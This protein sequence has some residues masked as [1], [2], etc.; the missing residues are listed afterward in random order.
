M[1]RRF[2]AYG[3]HL[4]LLLAASS[5]HMPVA[6]STPGDCQRNGTKGVTI[7]PVSDEDAVHSDDEMHF[8]VRVADSI[9]ISHVRVAANDMPAIEIDREQLRRPAPNGEHKLSARYIVDADEPGKIRLQPGLNQLRIEVWDSATPSLCTVQ[10]EIGVHALSAETYAVLIGVNNYAATTKTL[11]HA[12]NDAEKMAEHLIAHLDV[13]RR[14]IQLLTDK[15][16]EPGDDPFGDRRETATHLNIQLALSNLASTVDKRGTVIFYYSGHGY[17][18][19]KDE[20]QF[21]DSHY[22]LAT[23]STLQV[24]DVTLV[25]FRDIADRLSAIK[26]QNKIVILDACFS[27]QVIVA[28]SGMGAGGRAK[29]LGRASSINGVA[30]LLANG[31]DVYLMSSSTEDQLSYEFDDLNHSIFTY[32]LLRASEVPDAMVQDAAVSDAFQY[33]EMSVKQSVPLRTNGDEQVPRRW[34]VGPIDNRTWRRRTSN[35]LSNTP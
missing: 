22:L 17:A 24:A 21:I 5:L 20:T 35:S 3:L 31:G 14:N 34:L 8:T 2:H 4:I 19:R 23:D 27:S 1:H 25:R 15:W 33:A 32:Y 10:E 30:M 9:R 28:Q 6:A 7:V 18:P 12:K 26:A 13:P 29:T 16:Q 11:K